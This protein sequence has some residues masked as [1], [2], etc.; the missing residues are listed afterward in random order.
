ML[1]VLEFASSDKHAVKMVY[2]QGVLKKAR[3]NTATHYAKSFIQAMKWTQADTSSRALDTSD[4]KFTAETPREAREALLA[5]LESK[6]ASLAD[7]FQAIDH[8]DDLVL[9]CDEFCDAVIEI[10]GFYGNRLV[11]KA[12]FSAIDCDSSGKVAFD[13]FLAWVRNTVTQ[14]MQRETLSINT[15]DE[16]AANHR[17]SSWSRAI[18]AESKKPWSVQRLKLELKSLIASAGLQHSDLL[19]AWDTSGDGERWARQSCARDSCA[20]PLTSLCACPRS[21]VTQGDADANE[22]IDRPRRLRLVQHDPTN[23][24]G[25]VRRY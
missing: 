8:T 16:A 3:I 10:L 1:A 17:R 14:K 11:P 9:D 22:T 4:W 6:G 12:I 24:Q 23:R 7:A 19:K 25:S 13:E 15:L 5:L 2:Y 20:R 18:Q 21:S